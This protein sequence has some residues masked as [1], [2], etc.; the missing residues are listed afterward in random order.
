MSERNLKFEWDPHKA[1][2]NAKRHKGITFEEAATV[3]DDPNALIEYDPDHSVEEH[4]EIITGHSDK[5][6]LL[7]VSFTE[8]LLNLIR[9]FS[10]RKPTQQERIRYEEGE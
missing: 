9:I 5:N 6:R 3:F 7:L 8:R 1:R 2:L 4:R 10:A